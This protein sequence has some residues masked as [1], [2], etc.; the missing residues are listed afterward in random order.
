M[1]IELETA[2]RA[3]EFVNAIDRLRRSGTKTIDLTMVDHAGT[4]MKGVNVGARGVYEVQINLGYYYGSSEEV[5]V[6]G[7]ETISWAD[8]DSIGELIK[9]TVDFVAS[10][11]KVVIDIGDSTILVAGTTGYHKMIRTRPWSEP[12]AELPEAGPKY[13]MSSD[14][15]CDDAGCGQCDKCRRDDA[16]AADPELE[17]VA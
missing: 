5:S 6:Y 14:I 9:E 7:I 1:K 16:I 3:M 10:E 11:F 15:D 17:G 13:R 2:T 8:A 12:V 4:D